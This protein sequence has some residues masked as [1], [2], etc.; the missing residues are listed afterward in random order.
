MRDRQAERV[1]DIDADRESEK[2]KEPVTEAESLY[3]FNYQ[4]IFC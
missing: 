4:P 1:R 3:S 2:D